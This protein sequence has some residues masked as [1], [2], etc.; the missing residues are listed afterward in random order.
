MTE[1]I[2]YSDAYVFQCESIVTDI[3]KEEHSTIITLDRTPFFAEGGGQPCDTGFIGSCRIFKV[4][5]ADGEIYHFTKDEV[6]FT[7][8]DTVACSVDADVRFSR[9]QSH[10]GEH[11]FSGVAHRL[12]GVENVGFHMEDTVMTVDFD[13]HLTDEQLEECV[14][15]SNE[16]VWADR[17]IT[18]AVY[19]A[20]EAAALTYRSK[21]DFTEDIRIVEID[22][23]DACACCA[24]HVKRTG[25]VGLI[26][27]T[28][29]VSHRGG[30]R[31]TLVCGKTATELAIKRFNQLKS[32]AQTLV[33]K[34]DEAVEAL[35]KYMTKADEA[36][37]EANMLSEKVCRMVADS[38]ITADR[39]TVATC[40]LSPAEMTK[41]GA[42]LR[43]KA[44][45]PVVLLSG[46][47]DRGYSYMITARHYP[48]RSI[49]KEINSA[50]C[51]RGGGR[52]EMIQGSFAADINTIR[53]YF[54]DFKL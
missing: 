23:I 16:A 31:I 45:W 39:I 25:E 34:Q 33:V 14:K 21:K 22:G 54:E 36:R 27:V 7:E 47:D 20:E 49:A 9:M 28:S 11:I 41:A 19:S 15:K 6:A 13:I 37:Y 24:P 29:A 43:E 52:D 3:R 5:E 38:V 50:L 53:K 12:F 48:L 44:E 1:K 42:I 17:A 2:Y 40:E 4:C 46:D 51:G 8:G 30:V 32:I 18:T 35:S 10:S 26:M